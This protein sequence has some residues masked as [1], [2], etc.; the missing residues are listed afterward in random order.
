MVPLSAVEDA[1]DPKPHITHVTDTTTIQ[2]VTSRLVST[3]IRIASQSVGGVVV[4]FPPNNTTNAENS[5]LD[6]GSTGS[7]VTIHRRKTILA[8]TS[9]FG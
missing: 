3:G 6:N 9:S 7:E 5:S 1:F 8:Y 4:A 2:A